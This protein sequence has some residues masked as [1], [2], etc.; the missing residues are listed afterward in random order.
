MFVFFGNA[1]VVVD[2]KKKTH[3]SYY[4][5]RK[6]LRT[7]LYEGVTMNAKWMGAR[8]SLKNTERTRGG[9]IEN[10]KFMAGTNKNRIPP[11][12]G[13]ADRQTDSD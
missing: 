13:P 1:N 2:E 4:F 5:Q 12:K 6:Q 11:S 8:T 10:R 7:K 9:N 3:H